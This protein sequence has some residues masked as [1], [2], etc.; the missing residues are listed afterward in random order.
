MNQDPKTNSDE[1]I[2]VDSMGRQLAALGQEFDSTQKSISNERKPKNQTASASEGRF[3]SDSELIGQIL[4]NK[5]EILELLGKGG[6]SVVYKVRH[7]GMGKIFAVK[8]L[9]LHLAD[10]DMS[11]KRFKQEAQA[12]SNLSHP[13]I[14]A[15]HD[16]GEDFHDMPYLVM[17]YIEGPSLSEVLKETGTLPLER[18][19]SIMQQVTS[20]LTHAHQSGIVHRDLKPSNIMITKAEGKEQ[21]KIVDFGIAKVISQS[22]EGAQQ[23]TQTGEIFGSPLYMSPE[24]CSGAVIDQRTDIYALGCVMYEALSGKLPHKG[25]SVIETMHKHVNDPPPPLVAP[26]IPESDKQKLEV[27]LLKCLAKLPE[28]RFQSVDEMETEL[29]QIKMRSGSGVLSKLAGAWDLASAKRRAG[30]KTK[31][32]I[33]VGSLAACMLSVFILLFGLYQ[34]DQQLNELSKARKVLDKISEAESAFLNLGESVR[35]YFAAL[36]FHPER[37]RDARTLYTRHSMRVVKRI[38]EVD[39]LLKGVKIKGRTRQEWKSRLAEV[40]AAVEPLKGFNQ[41]IASGDEQQFSPAAI[42]LFNHL[43]YVSKQS[44]AVLQEMSLYAHKLEKKAMH[45]FAET[46]K[47]IIIYSF[48]C[49]V[50]NGTVMLSLSLHFIR[51]NP[52]LKKLADQASKLSRRRSSTVDGDVDD[53]EELNNVL[54]EL[55]EALSEAE[56][57]EKAL[58]SKLKDQDKQS[59]DQT[60]SSKLTSQKLQAFSNKSKGAVEAAKGEKAITA[61]DSQAAT[62]TVAVIQLANDDETQPVIYSAV[63]KNN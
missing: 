56:Q 27:M 58:L 11:L 23:L 61:E 1:T 53:V 48:I 15:V 59:Q 33:L 26:Q 45:D 40:P 62:E 6:M 44:A 38:E 60:G 51:G 39:E 43:S 41:E 36:M 12:S 49:V 18:F 55:A 21:A 5:Y 3:S 7:T 42:N 13:G 34:A 24:Q 4:A 30:K 8:L 17:D 22:S 54:Q 35:E 10:D 2:G 50:I 16:Y 19:L 29:R 25:N 32:P 52:D 47:T 14:V 37:V 20:A 28:D 9:H 31:L 57:R 63:D 46:Q